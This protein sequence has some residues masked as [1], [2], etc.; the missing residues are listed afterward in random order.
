MP[1]PV[2]L[3]QHAQPH[4]D[5]TGWIA[6]YRAHT[7]GVLAGDNATVRLDLDN[8]PQ[9]AAILF[10]RPESGGATRISALATKATTSPLPLA[11]ARVAAVAKR[12]GGRPSSAMA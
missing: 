1:S 11:R 3:R 12:A 7:S 5:L 4:L 9:P 10:V 8:E 6:Y 2:R